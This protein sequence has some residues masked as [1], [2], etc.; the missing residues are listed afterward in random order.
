[1]Y[2]LSVTGKEINHIIRFSKDLERKKILEATRRILTAIEE[3]LLSRKWSIKAGET[4]NP[5]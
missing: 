2:C 5:A 4:F 3:N 1:M